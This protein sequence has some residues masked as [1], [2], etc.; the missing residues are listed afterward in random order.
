[1]T[2]FK[3]SSPSSSFFFPSLTTWSHLS[4]IVFAIVSHP[5][6]AFFGDVDVG[7]GDF[8]G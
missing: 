1:M 4:L 8:I 3:E 6:S 2:T 5:S 7:G